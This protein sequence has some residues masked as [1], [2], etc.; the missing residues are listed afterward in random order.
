MKLSN[1][2]KI[3]TRSDFNQEVYVQIGNVKGYSLAQLSLSYADYA[4]WPFIMVT[5]GSGCLFSL[6]LILG[7]LGMDFDLISP[8]WYTQEDE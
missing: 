8:H 2:V 6:L 7:K 1:L 4:S 3:N 5:A